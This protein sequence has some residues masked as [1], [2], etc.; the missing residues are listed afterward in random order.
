MLWGGQRAGSKILRMNNQLEEKL[1][2]P[3]LS[4]WQL[5]M[6]IKIQICILRHL[7]I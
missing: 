1:I 2:F 7:K 4:F 3:Q 6:L 5:K